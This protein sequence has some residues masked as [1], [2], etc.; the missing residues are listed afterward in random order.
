MGRNASAFLVPFLF[1]LQHNQGDCMQDQFYKRLENVWERVPSGLGYRFFVKTVRFDGSVI[2]SQISI[3]PSEP[4]VLEIHLLV[5]RHEKYFTDGVVDSIYEDATRFAHHYFPGYREI[6][7]KATF[8][9]TTVERGWNIFDVIK[10]RGLIC[11]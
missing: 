1:L 2:V 5:L 7:C 3:L 9:K 8:G 11:E 10:E 4:G 6:R